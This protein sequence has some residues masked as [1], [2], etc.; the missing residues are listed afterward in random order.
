MGN[1]HVSRWVVSIYGLS[2]VFW[3]GGLGVVSG[4]SYDYAGFP[5]KRNFPAAGSYHLK[6][7]FG[8]KVVVDLCV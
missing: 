7:G 6:F 5:E 2:W 1:I 4:V 3:Q 8:F